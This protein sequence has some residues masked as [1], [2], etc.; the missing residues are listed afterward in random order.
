MVDSAVLVLLMRQAEDEGASAVTLRA[1][2]EEASELGAGRALASIGLSDARAGG[3]I[4]ELR[5]LL[6]AWRD[7]KRTARNEVIGWMVRVM[8]ALFVLGLA[9]KLGLIALVRA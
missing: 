5:Q 2:V 3:D 4:G 9:V 7:A 8:L 6:G 1:V